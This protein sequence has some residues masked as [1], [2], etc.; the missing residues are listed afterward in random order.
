MPTEVHVHRAET[1]ALAGLLFR[2]ARIIQFLHNDASGLLGPNS[3]SYWKHIPKLYATLER[4]ALRRSIL[5]ILFSIR[6]AGRVR[7]M[8][9]EVLAVETWFDDKVFF[10]D[11]A[12]QRDDDLKILMVGRLEAQ[13]DP[14]LAIKTMAKVLE[15]HPQSQLEIVGVG[16]LEEEMVREARRLGVDGHMLFRGSLPRSAVADA[17]RESDVLLMTSHYEGSPRVIV[18][19]SACGLPIACTSG[20]DPDG[21]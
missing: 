19:A 12:K 17:M 4:F 15:M 9:D 13:K 2:R 11:P 20:A 6:D 18:E 8:H 21:R 10:P 5:C 3:D 1:G 16:S 7:S 14:L